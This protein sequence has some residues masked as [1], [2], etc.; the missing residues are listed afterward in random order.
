MHRDDVI[1]WVESPLQ[2]IGAAEWAHLHR[3]SVPI[4]GRLT[5][6]MGTTADDLIDRG[7]L[8]GACE[9]YLGVPWNALRGHAHWL[10]GDGFSG[11][12]RLAASV[13][14]PRRITFLDD[15]ANAIAYADTLLGDRGYTRPGIVEGRASALTAPFA[16]DRVLRLAARGGVELFTAF[17]LG[18]SRRTR[19]QARGVSVAEHRF[20]F[21]RATAKGDRL[22]ADRVILGSARPVDGRMPRDE[23]LEWVAR[24]AE[25]GDAVYLPHRREPQ[26]Q[27]AAVA[28]IDGVDVIEAGLPA[29]LVLAGHSRPLELFT[30]PSSTTTTL[31]HVLDGTGSVIRSAPRTSPVRTAVRR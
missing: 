4:A 18:A 16:L 10:V 3:R 6:Q 7:A 9:P 31:S 11:Q 2:L 19:L 28:G 22:A 30:L 27:L 8:F 15:G 17:D 26:A 25:H 14:R 21:T 29:E 5:A 1:A 13:L 12:F 23:Y 24:I 20:G